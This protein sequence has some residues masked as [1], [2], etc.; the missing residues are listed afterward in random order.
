M[1]MLMPLLLADWHS[2]VTV[3]SVICRVLAIG[4]VKYARLY[5]LLKMAKVSKH[6]IRN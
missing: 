6:A 3:C 2:R 1:L 5:E 4:Q